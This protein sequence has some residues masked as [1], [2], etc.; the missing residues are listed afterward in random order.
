[1]WKGQQT[2]GIELSKPG[3]EPGGPMGATGY[4]FS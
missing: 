2:M 4:F 3:C 1:M